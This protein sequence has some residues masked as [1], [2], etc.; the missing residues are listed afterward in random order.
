MGGGTQVTTQETGPWKGQQKYLLRGFETA[1]NMYGDVPEYYQGETV[2]GFDPAEKA[3]QQAALGYAMG[4]RAAAQQAG[5]ERQLLDTYGLS[6]NL[7]RMG[8]LAARRGLQLQGPLSEGQYS[9][10]TPYSHGQYR[11]LLA[12]NVRTGAGTPYSAMENALT[13]GVIGNLQKNVLP[14]IRQQQVMYQPGGSSRGALEQNKAVT[15]A[16][17][18]GLTKP[19][20]QMYSD[21]YQT[22]QGMR[23]PAAQMGLGAQQFGM[24][25]GLAG[26]DAARQA[27]GLGLSAVGQYPSIMSAPL[28]MYAAMGDVGARRRA[29][30]QRGMDADMARYQ[31]NAT[32]PQQALANYISA[33]QGNYGS[34][35]YQTS[36]GPSALSQI[37]Q[38]VGIAGTLA[39]I[40]DARVKENIVPEGTK[41]K[42]LNVYT[43]NYIGDSTPRR[44]VMAQEV[45]GIYPDAVGEVRGIKYVDYG[46]I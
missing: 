21:A 38:A 32:M 6:K 12:G 16:T 10:L 4:P 8:G 13:Q 7:S 31:Y 35:T 27:G 44:G 37:G 45:E 29:M 2:A 24:N 15:E 42:G 1:K 39:G 30:T 20:A 33:I 36:P 26:Q 23:M 46:A 11:D 17:T 3:A 9:R 19:L 22:A 18:A 34:Q 14:G 5:A 25:Y 40:S 28:G 43:Y 41:W